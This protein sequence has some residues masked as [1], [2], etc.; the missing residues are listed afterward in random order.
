M[1]YRCTLEAEVYIDFP[2]IEKSKSTYLSEAYAQGMYR[3]DDMDDV[4]QSNFNRAMTRINDVA[5]IVEQIKEI[6][7]AKRKSVK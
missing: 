5:S 7:W 3:F 2:D 1:K 6:D 4:I